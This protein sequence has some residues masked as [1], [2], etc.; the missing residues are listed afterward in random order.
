MNVRTL[1]KTGSIVK[2]KRPIYRYARYYSSTM[3][4]MQGKSTMD[5]KTRTPVL[6]GEVEKT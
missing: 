5:M 1:F 2:R 3:N 6:V 4:G